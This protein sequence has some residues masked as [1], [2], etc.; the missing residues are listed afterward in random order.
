MLV[1]GKDDVFLPRIFNSLYDFVLFLWNEYRAL[2]REEKKKYFFKVFIRILSGTLNQNPSVD[3]PEA[4]CTLDHISRFC[5][6]RGILL[7]KGLTHNLQ[8][9]RI[10]KNEHLDVFQLFLTL[11]DPF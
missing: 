4:A 9:T 5:C 10:I 8:A 7:P 11:H 1:G 6:V 3:F 2:C